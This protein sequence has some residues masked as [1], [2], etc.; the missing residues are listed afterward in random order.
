MNKLIPADWIVY[1]KK[2]SRFTLN[3]NRESAKVDYSIGGGKMYPHSEVPNSL[4]G[5]GMGKELVL[6]TFERLTEEG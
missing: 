4:R 6:K 1:D 2:N 5:K 3:I